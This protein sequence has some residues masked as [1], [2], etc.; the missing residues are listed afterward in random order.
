MRLLLLGLVTTAGALVPLPQRAPP[1]R[2]P[3]LRAPSPWLLAARTPPPEPALPGNDL[4]LLLRPSVAVGTGCGLLLL[5]VGNRLLTEELANSQGRADLLAAIAAVLIILKAAGDVDITPRVA[6]AVPLE[7][8]P[9]S[10]IEPSLPAGASAELRW[11]ADALLDAGPC[12]A[13]ALWCDDRTLMLRGTLPSPYRQ[14]AAGPLLA[15]CVGGANGAPE[16]LPAL[17]LLPGRVEFSY[18]PEATQAVLMVPIGAGLAEGGG[19]RGALVLAADR[20]RA[21]GEDDIGWARAVAARVGA[22]LG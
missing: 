3:P 15:K 21:F 9:T 11:A 22:A 8:E 4:P 2:A 5:L 7:G 19:S 1:L 14:V 12:V 6:E 13:V 17:Q 10:W 16:Y 18:L 20:Q